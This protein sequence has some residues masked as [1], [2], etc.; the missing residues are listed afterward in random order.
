[1]QQHVIF[2]QL[3][4]DYK[5]LL[6]IKQHKQLPQY[7]KDIDELTASYISEIQDRIQKVM[8]YLNTQY[9]SYEKKREIIRDV[10]F[11]NVQPDE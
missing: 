5:K 9:T 3:T 7:D 6:Y 4:N 2:P 11:S 8:H 1:M 10:T